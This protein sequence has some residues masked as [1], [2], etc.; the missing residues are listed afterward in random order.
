MLGRTL[1]DNAQAS[2]IAVPSLLPVD[3]QGFVGWPALRTATVALTMAKNTI[4]IVDSVPSES[5]DWIKLR[6]RPDRDTLCVE[7]PSAN[8]RPE[9]TVL[10]DTGDSDGVHLSAAWWAQWKAA[11]ARRPI[12]LDASY[13]P[14]AGLV[15]SE[16]SWA[17]SLALGGI[18]LHEVAV[19]QSNSAE[20]GS[21][22]NR[23]EATLGLAALRRLDLVVDGKAGF[24]Y[25]HS[26][27]DPPAP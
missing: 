19:M 10:I 17:H 27:T 1:F 11:H 24:I 9:G 12:T 20:A 16:I 18:V 2:V 8:G 4:E 25:A 21:A 5:E 6:V 13:T 7:I 22:G 26:R 3:I 23:Y 14:A 15:V